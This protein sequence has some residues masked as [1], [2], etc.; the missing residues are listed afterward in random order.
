MDVG[1]AIAGVICVLM[2]FGHTAIGVVWVL[3]KLREDDLPRTPFGP[4]S[5][6][7]SMIR[8]TWFVVTLFCLG[9]GTLLLL[10][11]ADAGDART[12]LLR[13]LAATW[14]AA[15]GMALAL[16]VRR[17]RKVRGLMRLPVPVLWVV[18]A[19]LCW[20]ASGA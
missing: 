7:S 17:I 2:A 9:V 15:T 18:V 1:L 14:T 3:P 6:T 12:L 5:M 4:Q 13:T 11:A 16:T 20:Q 10:V 8:V 19:I